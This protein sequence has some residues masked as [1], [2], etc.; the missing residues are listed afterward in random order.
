MVKNLKF[1]WNVDFDSSKEASWGTERNTENHRS[2]PSIVTEKIKKN[3]KK[4]KCSPKMLVFG[5]FWLF[6]L[7]FS[8]TVIGK[9]LWFL[10]LRS[11]PQDAS[12]ELLK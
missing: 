12:I 3:L 6:F 2:L 7:I 1:F 5:T 11:F 8:L 4:L 9:T 10:V